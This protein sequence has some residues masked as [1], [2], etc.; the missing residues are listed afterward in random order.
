MSIIQPVLT[1]EQITELTNYVNTYRA[2]NQAPPMIWDATISNFS[3]SWSNYLLTNNVFKHS[4]TPLYGE[5]LAWFQ[6]YGTDPMSLLKKSIDNWYNEISLY[7]FNNPGFSEATGHFTCLVW[8]SS[9]KFAMGISIDTTTN[10]VDVTMN[11]SPPGNVI[12]K[13]AEN[14]LPLITITPGP[15]PG[16]APAPAPVPI[17]TPIPSPVP[18]PTIPSINTK[19]SIIDGLQIIIYMIQYNNN[20]YAIFNKVSYLSQ[21]VNYCITVNASNPTV[22]NALYI[23]L[24]NIN[25]IINL[26]QRRQSKYTLI[27]FIQSIIMDINNVEF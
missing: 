21:Q 2:K 26:L 8:V 9:T 1:S 19:Q 10:T 17:P 16:P 5:N 27:S 6:G 20:K 13:F 3:Q 15:G 7:D 23:V 4:G 25:S 14:V 11:T 12:G 24:K 22:T 18:V